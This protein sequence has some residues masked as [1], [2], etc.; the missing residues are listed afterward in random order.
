MELTPEEKQA[1]ADSAEAVK[2]LIAAMDLK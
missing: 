2:G 1:L